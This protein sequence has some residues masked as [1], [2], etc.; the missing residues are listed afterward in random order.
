MENTNKNNIKSVIKK[1]FLKEFM[2]GGTGW[3]SN[4]DISMFHGSGSQ[5]FPY[6]GATD[7][8]NLSRENSE[9]NNFEYINKY[10]SATEN[11]DVYEFPLE[12]FKNG[13]KIEV[14]ENKEN[15]HQASVFET[16]QVVIINL[17]EDPQ[18]YSKKAEDGTD[19]ENDK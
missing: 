11:N 17:S 12:E 6:G 2:N 7:P 14:A 15:E 16:A 19:I 1:T 10:N 3:D 9:K 4:N 13:L 18:F 5:D 8:E